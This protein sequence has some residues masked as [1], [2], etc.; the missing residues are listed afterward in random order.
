MRL[1]SDQEG[2][3]SQKRRNFA[4]IQQILK[5]KSDQEGIER[6]EFSIFE[7]Y[8]IFKLKSDQEGIESNN[9][10][11]CEHSNSVR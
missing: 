5:L 1:K 9:D 10:D 8:L 3:E 11:Y 7:K 4:F 2:I 6:L